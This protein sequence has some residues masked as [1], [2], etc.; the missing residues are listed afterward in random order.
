MDL[1]DPE[2]TLNG[3]EGSGFETDGSLGVATLGPFVDV[4]FGPPSGGHLG[5][6]IGAGSIGLEDESGDFSNGLG[7]ALFGGYDWWVS[8]QWAP[9]VNARY[10]RLRGERDLGEVGTVTDTANTVGLMFSALYH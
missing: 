6:V 10:L 8:D 9:G 2:L 1:S 5:A 4:F 7:L 3:Q